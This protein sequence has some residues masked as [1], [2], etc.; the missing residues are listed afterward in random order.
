M[1]N[2]F[3]SFVLYLINLLYCISF[4]QI[5]TYI[6]VGSHIRNV[7]LSHVTAI[8]HEILFARNYAHYDQ[9]YCQHW[10]LNIS[11][12]FWIYNSLTILE[13]VQSWK[14]KNVLNLR[15]N[16]KHWSWP[17]CIHLWFVLIFRISSVS[18]RNALTHFNIHISEKCTK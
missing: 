18:C 10:I 6:S 14:F 2:N 9:R 13:Y 8:V 11:L 7:L 15:G 4:F 5:H 17:S 1:T 16:R 3:F 12:T